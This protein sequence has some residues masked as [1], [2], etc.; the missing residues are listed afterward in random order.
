MPLVTH[1]ILKH[2]K[3]SFEKY[4]C[5]KC[6]EEEANLEFKSNVPLAYASCQICGKY[7]LGAKAKHFKK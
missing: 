1:T 2:K 7:L 6:L 3:K 5:F 4:I